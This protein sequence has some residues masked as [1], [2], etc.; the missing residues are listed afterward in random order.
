MLERKNRASSKIYCKDLKGLLPYITLR[1]WPVIASPEIRAARPEHNQTENHVQCRVVIVSLILRD[2]PRQILTG[3]SSQ[4]RGI[5]KAIRV[6][7]KL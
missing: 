3:E 4:V 1:P 6:K 2:V 7:A 5:R